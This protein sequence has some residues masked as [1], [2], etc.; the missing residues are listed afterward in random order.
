MAR[1]NVVPFA[2]ALR[3]KKGM[4]ERVSRYLTELKAVGGFEFSLATPDSEQPDSDVTLL[5][6]LSGG[7]EAQVLE[8]LARS[9][10][11]ALILAHPADNA[12]AAA[13]EVLA[14]LNAAETRG[15]IVQAIPGWQGELGDLLTTFAARARMERAR[16]GVIG[17][18]TVEVLEPWRL[19]EQVKRVWGP[20]L[21]RMHMQELIEAVRAADIGQAKEAASEFVRNAGGI[22]E[23]NSDTLVGAGSIYVGLKDLVERHHLNAV[24][25]KCF[26]LLPVF[27]NTGCY[28]LARLNEEGIPAGCEAD[29]LSTLGMLFLREI[30]GQP[31]FMANPSVI[32]QEE[33]KITLAHCTIGRSMTQSYTIRSHFESGI[34]VGIQGYVPSGPVTIVRIGGRHLEEVL[35]ARGDLLECGSRGDMCRTQLTI[36][37][38]D[39]E[40]A[41]TILSRPLG[42][43]HLVLVGDWEKRIRGFT[44]LFIQ[45]AKA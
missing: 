29:V 18:R 7:V 41:R 12:V 26:D 30:T 10:G 33:G 28:A 37:L 20:C 3:D 45:T 44:S 11:P 35:I 2:S 14:F 15:R 19:T 39:P 1:V 6:V 5:L 27:Q 13:V 25:V 16:L 23:P 17:T 31:S 22:V 38:A 4:Q 24:T 21:V 9:H 34:G 43:H 42:N 8:F 36:E 32:H 40:V